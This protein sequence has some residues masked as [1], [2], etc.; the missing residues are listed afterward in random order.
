[1]KS[2]TPYLSLVLS[3]LLL[4][5]PMVAET[6]NDT[7]AP[8]PAAV[9]VLDQLP[10]PPP[11]PAQSVPTVNT[12]ASPAPQPGTPARAVLPN[13]QAQ[14]PSVSVTT[15]GA[16]A[17]KSHGSSKKWL[18][19]AVVAGGAAGAMMAM[20]GGKGSAPAA[21]P[22]ALSIGTPGISIGHP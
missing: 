12:G 14:R 16:S 20:K 6:T 15:T 7:V 21:A 3:A 17:E 5:A 9:T 19:A 2:F 11:P 4:A 22:A 10:T 18:I 1:M 13:T 8:S